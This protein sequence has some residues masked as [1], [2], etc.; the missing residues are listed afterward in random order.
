MFDATKLEASSGKGIEDNDS[1]LGGI[2]D[3]RTR[4]EDGTLASGEEETIQDDG[5]QLSEADKIEAAKVAEE[6]RVSKLTPEEKET[7]RVAAEV[8]ANE[9]K[10]PEQIAEAKKV[11]DDLINAENTEKIKAEAR[12]EFLK[13]FGVN[14]EEEL[15]EKLNPTK[16]KTDE[17]KKA[18]AEEYTANLLNFA[19]KEKLFNTN[20]FA[21]LQSLKQTSD[22]DLAYTAF[23]DQ[24]KELNK[25]RLGDDNKPNPVSDVEIKEAFNMQYHVDSEDKGLKAIGEKQIK[26]AADAKRNELEAKYEDAKSAYDDFAYREKNSKPFLNFINKTVNDNIPTQLVTKGKDGADIVYNIK[27]PDLKELEKIFVNDKAFEDYLANGESQPAKDYI[28]KTIEV[29]L[30][31]KNKDSILSNVAD[32]S[33]SAGLKAGKVGSAAPFGSGK[34]A[35]VNTGTEKALTQAEKDKLAASFGSTFG[36]R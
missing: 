18:D 14:S 5:T 20:D 34:Q 11:A 1:A 32:V 10:T 4:N 24:Y 7:E 16:P 9:G 19:T 29:Y 6:D 30:W 26:T 23:S 12:K 13:S 2:A 28:A 15:K 35:P 8:K 33:Y 25:D 31:N 36:R 27:N 3:A 21:T 17:E 22:S